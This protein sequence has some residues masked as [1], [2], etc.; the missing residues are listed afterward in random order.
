MDIKNAD[1]FGWGPKSAKPDVTK[2]ELLKRYVIGRKVADIG[3]ATGQYAAFLEK[4]KKKVLGIDANYKL[5]STAKNSFRVRGSISSLPVKSNSVDTALVFDLLEHLEEESLAEVIRITRS[6]VIITV[7]RTTDKELRSNW[8]VFGHHQ[9]ASHRRSYTLKSARKL[10]KS[11]GLKEVALIPIHP[12]ST[13]ALL[14]DIL[15]GSLL[16]RKL[17]RKIALFLA[18]PKKF[19]SNLAIVADI[20]K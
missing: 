19:C 12:I 15:K 1:K 20:L 5:L 13:E 14:V 4:R 11:F 10:I 9:D 8:L 16:K 6:R 7:P 2:C 3:C 17:I 18:E